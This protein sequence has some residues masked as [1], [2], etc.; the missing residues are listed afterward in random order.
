MKESKKYDGFSSE[1]EEPKKYDGFSS[2]DYFKNN[3]SNEP[4]NPQNEQPLPDS[5]PP[6][7]LN[8]I[9]YILKFINEENPNK[10]LYSKK[11]NYGLNNYKKFSIRQYD[12][13]YNLL[14]NK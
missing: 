7:L 10:K 11:L 9:E 2:K 3:P 13:L 4:Q 5:N 6:Q 8:V 14:L 12:T 1:M